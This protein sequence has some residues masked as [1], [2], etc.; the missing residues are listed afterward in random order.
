VIEE[1]RSAVDE[2]A[3]VERP[4]GEA[5]E[6]A[7]EFVDATRTQI[8]GEGVPALEDLRQALRSGDNEAAREATERLREIDSDAANDAARDLGAD[9]CAED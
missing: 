3:D 6:R 8:E 1:L 2:L 7:E 9:D 5:G 4:E